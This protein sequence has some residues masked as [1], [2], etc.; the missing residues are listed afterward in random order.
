MFLLSLLIF[1]IRSHRNLL[2]YDPRFQYHSELSNLTIVLSD[3]YKTR[4]D[5]LHTLQTS[6]HNWLGL[7]LT[8]APLDL[9]SILQVRISSDRDYQCTHLKFQRYL[10]A[11]AS[12]TTPQSAE[13][14]ASV[15][16]QF[17]SAISP[18]ERKIGQLPYISFRV[19]I[20]R[21]L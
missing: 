16:L 17:A 7:A 4:N 6:V 14:G 12:F 1:V 13:L 8:R 11:S 19:T 5:I 21:N 20:L 18:S 2:Q 9:Q 10:V 15:A 3:S